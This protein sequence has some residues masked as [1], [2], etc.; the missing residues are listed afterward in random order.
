MQTRDEVKGLHNCPEFSQPL[1]CLYQA[2]QTPEKVFYCFYKNL[3]TSLRKNAK[4][5]LWHR[6]KEKFLPGQKSCTQKACTRNQFLFSIAKKCFSKY[7]FFFLK[8]QLKRKKVDTACLYSF[9][10]RRNG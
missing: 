1:A 10:R 2:M 9:S 4:L 3:I 7:R 8:C 5:L 6:L